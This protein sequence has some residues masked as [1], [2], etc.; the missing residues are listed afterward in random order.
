MIQTNTG[1]S[2]NP[3]HEIRNIFFDFHEGYKY[4]STR[5]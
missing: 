4:G 2:I 3:V 1:K 5:D